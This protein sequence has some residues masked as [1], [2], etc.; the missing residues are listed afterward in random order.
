MIEPEPRCGQCGATGPVNQGGFDRLILIHAPHEYVAEAAV[1]QPVQ[2]YVLMCATCWFSLMGE[3]SPKFR[4]FANDSLRDDLN[5]DDLGVAAEAWDLLRR[6]DLTSDAPPAE[7]FEN[8]E[9]DS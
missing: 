1:E 4:E 3:F 2:L 9:E 5:S 6:F 7:W 8:S